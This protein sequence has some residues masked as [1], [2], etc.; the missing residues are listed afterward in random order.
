MRMHTLLVSSHASHSRC[1]PDADGDGVAA[2]FDPND[3]NSTPPAV[4]E[5]PALGS[6]GVLLLLALFVLATLSKARFKFG[7][8]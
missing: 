3:P 2:G 6:V 1:C 5:V 4:G 7:R 8:I